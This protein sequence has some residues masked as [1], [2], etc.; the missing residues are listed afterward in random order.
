MQH[1]TRMFHVVSISVGVPH[2]HLV[3]AVIGCSPI[4]TP[5]LTSDID[6]GYLDG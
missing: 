2:P 4:M 5:A 3:L 6:D 1:E